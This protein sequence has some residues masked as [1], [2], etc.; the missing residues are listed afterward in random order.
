MH[1]MIMKY[2][3]LFTSILFF[4]MENIYAQ[5][6]KVKLYG[7]VQ[8]I[9]PGIVRR[10]NIDESGRSIPT[11]PDEKSYTY[12]LYATSPE[13]ITPTELWIK[14]KAYA[15]QTDSILTSPVTIADP[16]IPHGRTITLVPKSTGKIIR[17]SPIQILLNPTG[18][19]KALAGHND[20]LLFYKLRGKI[21]AT[22]LSKLTPLS[23]ASMQ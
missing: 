18:R 17:I 6:S 22:H 19:H 1:H 11:K 14:G 23:P 9:K 16:N 21:Y 7:F 15:F 20:I 8:E 3:F 12:Y 13:W 5:S 10:R 4:H 2:L